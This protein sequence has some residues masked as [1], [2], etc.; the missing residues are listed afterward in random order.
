MTPVL[1]TALSITL[2]L[3]VIAMGV[4]TARVMGGP[5]AQDRVLALDFLYVVATLLML[6]LAIRYDSDMY[7]EGAML[8]ALFGFVSSL[9][10]AKFLL[11][12]EIIE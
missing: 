7:S 8:M 11:R 6:V 4:A 9:A 10:L 2:V 12:G 1:S 3:Y 5:T